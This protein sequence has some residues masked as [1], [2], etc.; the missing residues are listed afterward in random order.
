MDKLSTCALERVCA[1]VH[2][3]VCVCA[4]VRVCACVCVCACACACVCA[5]ACVCGCSNSLCSLFLV[6]PQEFI[7]EVDKKGPQL[8]T[9]G[10]YLFAMGS[11]WAAAGSDRCD[12]L[13]V[14]HDD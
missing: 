10:N 3:Y 1:C 7:L 5:R 8:Q 9:V 2:V 12:L 11:S 4:R 6:L 13:F 14:I